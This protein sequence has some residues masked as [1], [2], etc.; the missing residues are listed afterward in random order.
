ME[1]VMSIVLLLYTHCCTIAVCS[2]I[3]ECVAVNLTLVYA[4][5]AYVGIRQKARV[6]LTVS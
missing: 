6:N 5:L 1:C 2:Q 4:I 3:L